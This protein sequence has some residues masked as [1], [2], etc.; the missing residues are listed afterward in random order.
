MRKY[1]YKE[2][3]NFAQ[4]LG[5]INALQVRRECVAKYFNKPLKLLKH[6]ISFYG[7]M[8]KILWMLKKSEWTD[9][10]S[11]NDYIKLKQMWLGILKRTY[12]PR[13]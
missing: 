5:M 11:L 10:I 3:R 9:F 4:I 8:F 13:H 7:L 12:E 2:S 1:E 6:K